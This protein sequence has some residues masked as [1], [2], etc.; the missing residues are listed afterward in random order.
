MI[1]A[2]YIIIDTLLSRSAEMMTGTRDA[3]QFLV[4][5]SMYR[6]GHGDE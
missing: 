1:L 2:Y 6:L 3:F 5:L 4:V